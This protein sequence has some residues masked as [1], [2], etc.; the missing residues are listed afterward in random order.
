MGNLDIYMYCSVYIQQ[1]F[2]FVTKLHK[3]IMSHVLLKIRYI[4]ESTIYILVF[5][6]S[7]CTLWWSAV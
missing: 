1:N 6:F 7:S 2:K 5:L 4:N 3:P